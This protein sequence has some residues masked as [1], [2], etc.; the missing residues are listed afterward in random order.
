MNKGA[1]KSMAIARRLRNKGWLV[2]IKF[3]PKEFSYIIE[4]ARSEYDAPCDDQFV[5]KGMV[6]VEL[7]DM[8]YKRGYPQPTSLKPSLVDAMNSVERQAR[9]LE[10]R[11]R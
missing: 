5:G 6:C 8:T 1:K 11:D 9:E 3:M 2:T 4:G 10:K 7:M